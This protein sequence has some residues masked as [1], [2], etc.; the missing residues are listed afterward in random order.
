MGKETCGTFLKCRSR[1]HTERY[2]FYSPKASIIPPHN[3]IIWKR[4]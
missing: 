2:F 1:S 3:G 4:Y